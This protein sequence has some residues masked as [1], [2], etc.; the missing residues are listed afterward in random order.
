[1]SNIDRCEFVP[2]KRWLFRKNNTF[3]QNV[4][5]FHLKVE[6]FTS[7]QKQGLPKGLCCFVSPL[8]FT[9]KK[10]RIPYGHLTPNW[11]HFPHLLN[12]RKLM[13]CELS[14]VPFGCLS[15]FVA[16]F[17]CPTDLASL[18][19]PGIPHFYV[20]VM[21]FLLWVHAVDIVCE[22]NTLRCEIQELII[23]KPTLENL[24]LKHMCL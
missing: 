10:R 4:R 6:K 19:H 11:H 23:S 13:L 7:N 9:N 5:F 24:M 16:K 3:D 14:V 22:L 18:Y 1:M 12:Q 2:V 17:S 20:I 21:S 15:V 8:F